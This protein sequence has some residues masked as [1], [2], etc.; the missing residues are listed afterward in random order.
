MTIALETPRLVLREYTLNDAEALFALNTDPSVLRYVGKKPLS[1]VEEAAAQIVALQR[2]YAEVGYGRW[3][4]M[5]KQTGAHIGW[6][7]LKLRQSDE[8]ERGTFTDIGY[9]F[10][11]Q[12]WGQG[13]AAE[14]AEACLAYGFESL[15]LPRI[16]GCANRENAPSIRILE[17][18]GLRFVKDFFI[19]GTPS[20]WYQLWAHQYFERTE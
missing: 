5:S 12:S 4:V 8:D 17:K 2:Q 10:A 7:G 11:Q 1:T 20:V 6:C 3:A 15:R 13:L 9:R 14:A 18:L 16:V 19:E